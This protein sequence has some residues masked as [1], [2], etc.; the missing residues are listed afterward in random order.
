M[1]RLYQRNHAS[2]TC[3][4]QWPIWGCGATG[5]ATS[6]SPLANIV[7]PLVA[8]VIPKVYH[9]ITSSKQSKRGSPGACRS[10]N[11]RKARARRI[12]QL[13][14][15]LRPTL[16]CVRAG[17]ISFRR[18]STESPAP[19]ST[20]ATDSVERY[21]T[22]RRRTSFFEL[23]HTENLRGS[24]TL[25]LTYGRYLPNYSSSPIQEESISFTWP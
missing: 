17:L 9:P 21:Y 8:L 18:S 6:S 20:S 22:L 23:S 15:E 5:N 10:E 24:Q 3:P 25:F 12:V 13:S 14:S 2:T 11:I 1:A 7:V 16:F 19:R 4:R